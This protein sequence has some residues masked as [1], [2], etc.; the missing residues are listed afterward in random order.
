M[1]EHNIIYGM[2]GV[3]TDKVC[4]YCEIINNMKTSDI[5]RINY[6]IIYVKN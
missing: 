1:Y 4:V 5:I 6:F 3:I 2:D